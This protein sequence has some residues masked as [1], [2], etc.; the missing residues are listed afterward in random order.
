MNQALPLNVQRYVAPDSARARQF[1]GLIRS[2]RFVLLIA[3]ALS[4]L[5]PE[6]FHPFVASNYE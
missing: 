3:V 4:I 1:A 6:I 2:N 5:G